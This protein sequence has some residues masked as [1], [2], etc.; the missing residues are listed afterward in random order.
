GAGGY[1]DHYVIGC[2][3]AELLDDFERQRLAAFGIERTQVDVDDGPAILVGQL[4]AEP[5][6]IVVGALDFDDRG[7]V[8]AGG[9]NL[10]GLEVRRDEDERAQTGARRVGRDRAGQIAGGGTGKRVEA[11]G[12]REVGG[13]GDIAVFEG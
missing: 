3:P 9:A 4:G 6:D 2:P 10:A 7:A 5:V 12:E 13:D 1:R 8:R 11:V